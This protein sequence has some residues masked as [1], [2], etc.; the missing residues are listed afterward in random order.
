MNQYI[1]TCIALLG[2]QSP[3]GSAQ[4][5]TCLQEV[6]LHCAAHAAVGQLHPLAVLPLQA[7]GGVVDGGRG[8]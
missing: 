4:T 8:L 5:H 3:D 6:G 1:R 2:L 7:L